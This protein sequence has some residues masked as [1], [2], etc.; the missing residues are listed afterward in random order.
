MPT[1]SNEEFLTV[2][3]GEDAPFTHVT[4]FMHDPAN[5]PADQHLKA[6]MGN[7]FS[8][9]TIQPGSNQYF[10]ISI[11]KPDENG[12]A[13]RRKALYLRTPCIVLDDVKEK[14][15]VDEASK[16]PQPSW[17]LETSPGSEQ[18]GYILDTPCNDRAKV[19]NLLDGLVANGLAPDGKDPGMKGVTRYVRLPEGYNLKASKMVD[20]QPYKC[21]MRVWRPDHR[22]TIEQLAAPFAVDLDKP[23]RESRVD[24]AASIPDH[25]LLDVADVIH[26]KEIRS[27][28]RFDITCPWVDEHTGEIDNGSGIFTNSDGTFGFK[29]HHGACADRTGKHLLALLNEQV[30]GFGEQLNNWQAKRVFEQIQ[31]P[32]TSA[33]PAVPATPSQEPQVETQADV[34][35]SMV[36]TLRRERPDSSEAR[37]SAHGIL[38]LVDQFTEFDKLPWHDQVRD[39]MGWSKQDLKTILNDFRKDWYAGSNKVKPFY[40]D[41]V[42]VNDQNR[43]YNL[44]KNLFQ[45]PEAFQNAYAHLDAEARKGA[46]QDGYATKVDKLDYAPKKPRIFEENGIIYG[47][48]WS[49]RGEISGTE[50][51]VTPWLNHFDVMGWG[52]HRD[53][54]LKWLAFTLMH[55]DIKI[56]HMLVL[57]SREGGGKDFLLAPLV[58]AMREN[59]KTILGDELASNFNDFLM[60]TKLLCINETELADRR[61]ALALSNKLKPLAAAPPEKLRVNVKNVSPVEVRNIVNATMTTNS[62][63]PLRLGGMSRRFFAVWSEINVRDEDGETRPEWRKYWREMWE[64]MNN[65][66]LEH[67]IWYLRNRVDLSN[68]N[69]GEPPPA[70]EWMKEITNESKSPMETTVDAFIKARIGAFDA[71]LLTTAEMVQTLRAGPLIAPELMEADVSFFTPKRVGMILKKMDSAVQLRARQWQHGNQESRVWA[72]RDSFNYSMLSPTELYDVHQAQV[73]RIKKNLTVVK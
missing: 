15:S 64:W 63:T 65:G 69:A 46:L 37:A 68:F 14:L 4:S 24:G 27:D 32:V 73:A 66:G 22:V 17:V 20:G 18:W 61:E 39:L 70:T 35:Q 34:L 11:F 57:G 53:H 40:D 43:F 1:V 42:Y 48:M 62:Q 9:Y 44:K 36:D 60:A 10:T 28:G 31:E 50:G 41:V 56:N 52:E 26:I 30:P 16:L 13:R 51:D 29:C 19:E 47:N 12:K 7:W 38:K 55:P 2:V 49:N 59:C 58:A 72:V 23:R 6:W 5:I 8:R 21:Q 71:D 45:T 25:P 33:S 3:F 67:C 54:I